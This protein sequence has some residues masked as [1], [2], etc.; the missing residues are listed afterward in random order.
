MARATK[1]RCAPPQRRSARGDGPSVRGR[2]WPGRRADREAPEKRNV[3]INAG[4][5]ARTAAPGRKAPEA[6]RH[7]LR[8]TPPAARSRAPEARG[9]TPGRSRH[10]HSAPRRAAR[11]R[12]VHRQHRER[13]GGAGQHRRQGTGARAPEAPSHRGKHPGPAT[14]GRDSQSLASSRQPVA[15]A[16]RCPIRRSSS[17]VDLQRVLLRSMALDAFLQERLFLE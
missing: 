13:L 6:P 7:R 1:P 5:K 11:V 4:Q 3:E 15:A 14:A 10:A 2:A 16:N 12:E 9:K 17:G 8:K